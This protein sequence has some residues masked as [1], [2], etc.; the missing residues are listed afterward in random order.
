[1][2]KKRTVILGL[3]LLAFMLLV[4]A[5]NSKKTSKPEDEKAT[6]KE[7][8]YLAVTGDTVSEQG[9]CVLASRFTVGDKIVFRM[10]AIDSKTNK[11]VEDAKLQV[12]L[13]TGEV[14]DMTYGEHPPD[15]DNAAKFWTAAYPVTDKT[16]TGTLDYYVTAEAGE[17]K[18]EF[19]PFNVAPSLLTI[20]D[21]KAVNGQPQEEQK[22]TEEAA[23]NIK[24]DQNVNI[25][26]TNFKFDK[27]KY[28]VKAGE[29]VTVKLTSKE[30]SHGL[31][32]E[33]QNFSIGDPN[34]TAKF[35]PEK[36]GEFP[37]MCSVF[38]GEGHAGMKSTLVVVE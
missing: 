15:A 9:G 6:D 33:G 4:S 24:T 11:Q 13:S 12:H 3:L 38:C 31:T 1:M 25:V 8:G 14:L 35:T 17:K 20:V 7:S 18:G 5:C 34:G 23:A 36:P 2:V 10:D 32:I 22:T 26:A 29:E 37:I 27:D 16:P 30:G 19:R 28:Y 21:A